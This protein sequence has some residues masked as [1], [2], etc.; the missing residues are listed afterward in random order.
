MKT[1]FQT[2][3]VSGFLEEWPC[4]QLPLTHRVDETF[5]AHPGGVTLELAN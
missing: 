2:V 1:Q 3:P 4:L 5:V